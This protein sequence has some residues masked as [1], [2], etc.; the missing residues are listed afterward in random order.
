MGTDAVGDGDK[1]SR[2]TGQY[3]VGRK[4]DVHPLCTVSQPGGQRV[5]GHG[6][7]KENQR[8]KCP[9]HDVNHLNEIQ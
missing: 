5:D 2:N 4:F 1:D 9:V 3:E 8:G 7:Q 6:C